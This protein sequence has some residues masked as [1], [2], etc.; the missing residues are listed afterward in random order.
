MRHVDIAVVGGGIVGSSI[1]WALA[2]RGAGSVA[3]FERSVVASGS[4]GRTGA[5]L[6]R[7]YSNEPE[8]RL[9]LLGQS[10]YRD[11]QNEVGGDC[12]FAPAGIV[13]TVDTSPG[14][15]KN[16][17]RL[18]KN[19]ALQNSLG[20][21]SQV[22][23]GDELQAMQP[24]VHVS[25]IPLASF[26]PD[27]GYVNAIAANRSM[28]IAARNLGAEIHEGVVVTDI[29][30]SSGKTRGLRS[31]IGDVAADVVICATGPWTTGLLAKADLTIPISSLR[32]Q[33]AILQRPIVLEAGHFVFIDTAA[34]M[35]TRPW[36]PGTSLVGV[37]GG[38][39]HDEVDPNDF[40]PGNDPEY[41][42]QAISA[43]SRRIPA[44]AGAA[45]LHGH[46]GLY[47]MTPDTHPI[48]GETSIE[49]LYVAAG[50]SGAGFKKAP[51]VGIC[52]AE[53]I[54]GGNPPVDLEPF[55]IG[56]FASDNWK[57]PWSETEYTFSSDFGHKF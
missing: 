40:R 33:I 24:F 18:R 51:A 38:D 8:A 4:S 35:F 12:G 31:T 2:R 53:S 15:E 21:D 29:E 56:R 48:I 3:L 55:A 28:A 16:L 32:V 11:W 43:I 54:T 37:G 13:V 46:A 44:M 14:H 22:I 10:I 41:P 52:L 30:H 27:S 1:A 50:F 17:D 45:Y 36:G 47:D 19:I 26:E 6:R 9:A 20:I 23:T 25:D 34:G 39:Q 49:G 57:R 5:L 7:H 42:A